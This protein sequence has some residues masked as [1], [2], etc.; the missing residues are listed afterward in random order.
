MKTLTNKY[1]ELVLVGWVFLSL[2][3][4]FI[5]AQSC[6]F[7]T[8]CIPP[9]NWAN[10][11][12][13][14]FNGT[15]NHTGR[16]AMRGNLTSGRYI[17][18]TYTTGSYVFPSPAIGDI[19]D[20]GQIEVIAGSLDRKVY[21][22]RG[23]DGSLLWFYIT[24]SAVVSSPAI[25]DI[26]NDG[27]IEV[28][29]GSDSGKVYALK[30]TD[31][32]AL[33][34]Y[35][36][37]GSVYSSPAIGDINNDGN[38]EVVVGS[39][40]SSV[41]ALRGTDGSLLW[42]YTTGYYVESSPAIGD[43]N[44]DGQ[45]EIVVGSGDG[46]VYALRGTNG[47]LL[48]SYATGGWVYS[49]PAIG[50]INNDGQIEV[51]VGSEDFKVYALRGTDGS[52]IWSYTTGSEVYSSPAIGDINNDGQIEVV[53]GS[54][55]NSLYI[56]RGTNGS[57]VW[58][59]SVADG[60]KPDLTPLNIIADVDPT[61]GLEI[62]QNVA[63]SSC[64]GITVVSASGSILWSW[65]LWYSHRSVSVGD[66]DGDGCVEIVTVGKSSK[67]SVIDA[68]SNEGGC[69]VL[70]NDD[71]LNIDESEVLKPDDYVEIFTTDGKRIYKG[72]YKNFKPE[73]RGIYF[74]MFK[75]NK[76]KKVVR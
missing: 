72:K 74:V 60:D 73:R 15:Q 3:P 4:E 61:P 11:S 37:G 55:D 17:K 23:T 64:C 43:I 14:M 71:E 38:I 28:V 53:V 5:N 30:G 66:V 33:W 31:G 19:N 47:S 57:L 46:K 54:Y 56:L 40:D 16:Q 51:V 10:G 41:Y 65:N 7:Q 58:Q 44:N 29:V 63:H 50:D 69:G 25:G 2:L 22:L 35:T 70:G 76:V 67:I 34:S 68:A 9:S 21:A 39:L 18:W 6:G 48:W 20:D 62:V 59:V 49:S 24:G 13:Q 26:N 32:S 45:I 12:W 8:T 36:T 75:G 52:F 1:I 42:S 27:N